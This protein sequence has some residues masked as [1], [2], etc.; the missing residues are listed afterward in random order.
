MSRSK[1]FLG[2]ERPSRSLAG[3]RR[4]GG[5]KCLRPRESHTLNLR[6]VRIEVIW[7]N[8]QRLRMAESWRESGEATRSLL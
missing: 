8:C 1:L 6:T 5:D 2:T 7:G 4:A 3:Q